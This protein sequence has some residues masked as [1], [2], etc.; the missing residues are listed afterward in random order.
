MGY[1][2]KAETAGSPTLDVRLR[3]QQA[4]Y[5][6]R[7]KEREGLSLS[8]VFGEILARYT[9]EVATLPIKPT[10]KARRHLWIEPRELEILN[11]LSIKWGVSK[12]EVARR[13]IDAAI[14]EDVLIV[15]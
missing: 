15:R 1:G 9:A 3:T 13:V 7:V 4:R 2:A 10:Q 14:A 11:R 5:L 12:G 8:R 6:E